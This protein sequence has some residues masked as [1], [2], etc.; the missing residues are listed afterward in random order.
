MRPFAILAGHCGAHGDPAEG[1]QRCF[2]GGKRSP[3]TRACRGVSCLERARLFS[4]KSPQN[5]HPELR[6]SRFYARAEGPRRSR[7]ARP[8]RSRRTCHQACATSNVRRFRARIKYYRSSEH[9]A[10]P[11]DLP[12]ILA[13]KVLTSVLERAW[14]QVL[15]LRATRFAQDDR[16]WGAL[17]RHGL[18]RNQFLTRLR[19]LKAHQGTY[20][21]QDLPSGSLALK[22]RGF[23]RATGADDGCG[24][25]R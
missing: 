20:Q 21:K 23:S 15:R 12:L 7:R 5:R 19:G 10:C 24:F 18:A 25:S 9:A 22:G 13:R 2:C 8:E 3:E 4:S 11:A 6:L 14:R 17:E 1:V 16:F